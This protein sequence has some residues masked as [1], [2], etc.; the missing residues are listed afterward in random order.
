MDRRVH[1]VLA[2]A[3]LYIA[4]V[5]L[6]GLLL[7]R[8]GGMGV[9]ALGGLFYQPLWFLG[10]YLCVVALTPLTLR[11]HDRF[12]VAVVAVLVAVITLLDAGR[13]ALDVAASGYLN[14]L[15]V[16]LLMHQVGFL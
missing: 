1:R 9:R 2:P 7:D 14:V 10:A 6:G 13:F 11:L 8:A 5:A 4:V 16:W 12:G 3:G 15:F